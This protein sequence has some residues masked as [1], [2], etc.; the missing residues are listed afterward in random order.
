MESTRFSFFCT[1]RRAFIGWVDARD[2]RAEETL[3][4]ARKSGQLQAKRDFWY[5]LFGRPRAG[6]QTTRSE[7]GQ[8]LTL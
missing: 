2:A 3:P 1:P 7:A 4:V 5:G 6:M 8:V